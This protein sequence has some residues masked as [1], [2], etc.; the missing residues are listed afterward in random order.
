MYSEGDDDENDVTNHSFKKEK[1]P[2]SK[3]M[4]EFQVVI[5][6]P[7]PVHESKSKEVT[8]ATDLRR[9]STES[10]GKC[11]IRLLKL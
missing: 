9:L 4:P 6:P 2:T 8:E 5:D 1:P 11:M 10:V 3:A 7:S